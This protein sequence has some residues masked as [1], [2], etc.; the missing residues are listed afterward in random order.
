VAKIQVV[1]FQTGNLISLVRLLMRQFWTIPLVLIALII[2]GQV[3]DL[4]L[5]FVLLIDP[6][7]I[8]GANR[9]CL[10]D[11]LAGSKVVQF[12]PNRPHV[13]SIAPQTV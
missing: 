8:F 9:R 1:D 2:P 11:L 12:K 13:D 10:H 3:D 5:N 4:L 7:M 6:L